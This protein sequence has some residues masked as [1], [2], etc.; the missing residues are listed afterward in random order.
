M[1]TLGFIGAGN[2]GMALIKGFSASKAAQEARL[3]IYDA[4]LNKR[5]ELRKSNFSVFESGSEIA[6]TCKYIVLACKPQQISELLQTIKDDLTAG[7]VLISLCAGISAEF[8]RRYTGENTKVILVMP[9][10]PML[11]GLGSSAIA[12]DE[13]VSGEEFAF[14]RSLIESCGAFEIIPLDKMNE[15]ICINASSPAF[16]YLFAKYFADYAAGQGI[17]EKA[18]LNLF[19][20][21]LIGAAK[22]MT[23]SGLGVN[24]LIEQV[25][26]KGGTTLAGLDEFY[27]GGLEKLVKSACEACTKR[28][29]ELGE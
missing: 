13:A 12:C 14:A 15:I 4:D 29:Y 3:H 11:L 8:I 25:S 10:M 1:T 5:D 18:A 28:A 6:K 24:E 26:S 23:D 20:H 2:M 21:A 19:S 22:M 7:T 16:I 17:N 9:N 27:S